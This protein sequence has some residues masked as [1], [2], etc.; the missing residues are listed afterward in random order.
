MTRKAA[1]LLEVDSGQITSP[2]ENR[3]RPVTLRALTLWQPIASLIACGAIKV[4]TRT[5]PTNTR[6]LVIHAAKSR[7][8]LEWCEFPIY[9]QVME[10]HGLTKELL[11]FGVAL[12]GRDLVDVRSTDS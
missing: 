4:E 1:R 11:P 2:G 8:G 9:R 6:P 7:E 10:Q 3:A 12:A 5:W